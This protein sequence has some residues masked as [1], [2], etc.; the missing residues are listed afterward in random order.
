M[1]FSV[2]VALIAAACAAPAQHL[3][4]GF[5]HVPPLHY[6]ESQGRAAGFVVDVINEAA[7]REGVEVGWTRVGGSNDIEK[8]LAG[9]RIDLYPAALVTE[10]RRGRFWFSEPW[11]S[12]DLT[13]LT[14]P[15]LSSMPSADWSGRRI[16]L[17]T[18]VYTSVASRLMPG[19]RFQVP[20]DYDRRG[21]ADAGAAMVCGGRSDGALMSHPEVLEVLIRR[22]AACVGV[23]LHLFEMTE[24]L[25]LAIMAREGTRDAG[26]RLRGRIDEMAR[27]GTLAA[28]AARHPRIPVRSAVMLAE[29]L[30]LRYRQRMLWMALAGAVVFAGVTVAFLIRG[31]RTRRALEREIAERSEAEQ[32]L[33]SRTRELTVSN[34]ELQAFGYSMSHD[35][36]EPVRLIGLY[37]QM[38]E[39]SS[40]PASAD[41]RF[42]LDTIRKNALRMQEMIE[43]LLLLSRIGRSD[44]ARVAVDLNR[45]VETVREDLA[46]AISANSAEI[47]VGPMP[48]VE[49]WPD[50]LSVLFHNLVGNAL[51]YRREE[52]PPLIEIAAI[53]GEQDWEIAVRDNGIGFDQEYAEK[54][55]GVFKRLHV[56]DKY[57][58]TGVGLAIAR[59]I[60][61]RHGGWIWAE[62]RP[63]D[64]STFRFKLPKSRVYGREDTAVL[65]K[66]GQLGVRA[67]S[68]AV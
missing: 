34:E 3:S 12:E 51:K 5:G 66:D 6:R 14:R 13:V 20:E 29:T 7:R 33:S 1:R 55:F 49:G 56:S 10:N 60:V 47:V 67:S 2:S 38:L 21:G 4:V 22:P 19:A 64:G 59:R 28:I 54:I 31:S 50:R 18:P 40:P 63:G 65:Q 16:V 62:G 27:D 35:L 9:G 15:N 8:A 25:P 52:V 45:V 37:S 24:S 53:E 44:T 11:W 68:G 57:G 36:R 42:F 48:T 17:A 30:R 39:R 32:A 41:S 43:Q 58:G 23:E 46:D 26:E 61:E